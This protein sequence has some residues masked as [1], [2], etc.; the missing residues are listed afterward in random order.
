MLVVSEELMKEKPLN[1]AESR[2]KLGSSVFKSKKTK[3]LLRQLSKDGFYNSFPIL[4]LT[5]NCIGS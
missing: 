1:I 3:E 4:I 5:S 2:R